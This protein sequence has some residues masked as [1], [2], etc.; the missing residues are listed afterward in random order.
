MELLEEVGAV[1]DGM[2]DGVERSSRGR[3]L[4]LKAL[5]GE[6]LMN[7]LQQSVKPS[8][9]IRVRTAGATCVMEHL[10]RISMASSIRFCGSRP[11]AGSLRRFGPNAPSHGGKAEIFD[12]T[13]DALRAG[14]FARFEEQTLTHIS[15]AASSEHSLLPAP[16]LE[17]KGR[18]IS[19]D[20]EKLRQRNIY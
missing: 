1:G 9:L 8:S 6:L 20:R 5:D 19:L 2:V 7:A 18:R 3:R 4:P 11:S 10:R 13:E 17:H 16:V 15:V 14:K 12:T